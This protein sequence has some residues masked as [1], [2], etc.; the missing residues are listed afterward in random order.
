MKKTEKVLSVKVENAFTLIELLVV[1][2]IIAI[3]AAMLLPALAKAKIKAQ[4]I[5][6]LNNTKQITIAWHLYSGDANDRVANNYGVSETLEAIT[7]TKTFDNWVNNVMT[8]GA[9]TATLDVS[10]TNTAWVVNG[11][12]GKYTSGAIGAYKCPADI[13][14]S[15]VQ[16]RA[17]FDRRNR[18][19]A[20][21][22]IF[23]RFS[24]TSSD[25]TAQGRNWGMS[26][27]R[28]FLKQAQVPRPSKTWLIL[29]E[30]PDSINDGYF[31]NGPGSG[32]WGDI[33]ASY[34]N[35]ACGFSFADGHSEIKKWK[36]AASKYG[37]IYSY[38]ATKSFDAAGRDDFAWYLE[39]TGLTQFS[40]GKPMFGY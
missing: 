22:S 32:N 38:P 34:H 30:H 7:V 35:G 33:P 6:C 3:L 17:G 21:N 27:Y 23:G 25:P 20:M 4:A 13:Y 2:A 19:L 26:E 9:S 37:V 1:I 36:S 10:N 5:G 8:W 31:I 16:S 15:P 40:D 12:L 18:S 29:D 28:Q 11:V 39:R 14:L 24:S